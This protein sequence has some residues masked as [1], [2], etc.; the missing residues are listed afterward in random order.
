MF[1]KLSPT[2][3]ETLRRFN[4]SQPSADDATPPWA[5]IQGIHHRPQ[6]LDLLAEGASLVPGCGL[7]FS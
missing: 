4:Q 6:L 2:G 7:Q 1:N 5:L 3:R